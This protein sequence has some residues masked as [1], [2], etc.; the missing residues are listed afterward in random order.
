MAAAAIIGMAACWLTGIALALHS[1]GAPTETGTRAAVLG[2]YLPLIP[3]VVAAGLRAAGHPFCLCWVP[4][5]T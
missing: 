3:A 1:L 5:P 2:F 4:A